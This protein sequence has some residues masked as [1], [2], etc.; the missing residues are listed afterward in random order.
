[1]YKTTSFRKKA[2]FDTSDNPEVSMWRQAT[3]DFFQKNAKP[4]EHAFYIKKGDN[5]SQLQ[6]CTLI[7]NGPHFICK[8]VSLSVVDAT[9]T[10]LE[11][12]KENPS[13][14]TL[15]LKRTFTDWR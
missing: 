3:P 13:R 11:R 5:S 6:K 7:L 1:M 2:F 12:K 10:N 14:I 15:I 4:L 9:L 8:Y